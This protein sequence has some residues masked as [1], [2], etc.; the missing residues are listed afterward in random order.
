MRLTI[1]FSLLFLLTVACSSK[2]AAYT[3]TVGTTPAASPAP[4]VA[5]TPKAAEQTQNE[6]TVSKDFWAKR[7]PQCSGLFYWFRQRGT[8]AWLSECKHEPNVQAFG[9]ELAPLEL[10]EAQRLSHVDPL[11]VEF[12]GKGTMTISTCRESYWNSTYGSQAFGEWLDTIKMDFRVRKIKSKWMV[13]E[14]TPNKINTYQI[15]VY[16]C[17]QI[18]KYLKALEPARSENNNLSDTYGIVGN[19]IFNKKTM[20]VFVTP[21][22]FFKDSGKR[23]FA[24]LTY[25]RINSLP[26]RLQFVNGR[27]L[28]DADYRRLQGQ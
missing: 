22:Q 27:K 3:A 2:P 6:L 12:E 9:E 8:E 4:T 16:T 15:P 21:N 23:S 14:I 17:A 1:T 20:V 19:V 26:P 7:I 11:P 10:T 25:D 13:D 24:G 18:E 5:P 28:T